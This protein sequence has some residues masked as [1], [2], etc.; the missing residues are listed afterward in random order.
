REARRCDNAI[1]TCCESENRI[2]SVHPFSRHEQI[3]NSTAN[4]ASKAVELWTCLAAR[5][6]ILLRLSLATRATIVVTALKAT[7]THT[8][9]GLGLEFNTP[10]SWYGKIPPESEIGVGATGIRR[11]WPAA[12]L[13]W[14]KRDT[15]SAFV[16]EWKPLFR[17]FQTQ[18]RRKEDELLSLV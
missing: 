17:A 8:R 10:L 2:A 13:A 14:R 7:P 12:S 15:R 18:H 16:P 1:A 4:S 11:N 3:P 9:I 5:K 6:R